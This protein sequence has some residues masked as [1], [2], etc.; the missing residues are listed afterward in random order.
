M[1]LAAID[2]CQPKPHRRHVNR[3]SY[4]LRKVIR[5][6]HAKQAIPVCEKPARD[7]LAW[8]EDVPDVLITFD[9]PPLLTVAQPLGDDAAP[10]GT[11]YAP[12]D[13]IAVPV[14]SGAGYVEHAPT[15]PEPGAFLLLGGALIAIY[16]F[17]RA[18]KGE[19]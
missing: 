9:A 13:Y 2:P 15:V 4:Q 17:R 18:V 3:G 16:L 19:P 12:V 7:L 6:H 10:G 1:T 11:D 5:A 8:H 14:G